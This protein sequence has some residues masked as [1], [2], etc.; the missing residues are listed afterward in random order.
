MEELLC[1]LHKWKMEA[2]RR[3]GYEKWQSGKIKQRIETLHS[4]SQKDDDKKWLM[5]FF[6]EHI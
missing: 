3:N 6:L 4:V 2:N 1:Q 5:Y